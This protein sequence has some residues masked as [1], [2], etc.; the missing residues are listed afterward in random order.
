MF[1]LHVNRP[2]HPMIEHLERAARFQREDRP[3]SSLTSSKLFYGADR[4]GDPGKGGAALIAA[5]LS[6]PT[7][8]RY[9]PLADAR[10][11][12]TENHRHPDRSAA[13]LAR[14]KP[15]LCVFEDLHWADPTT[16]E[17]LDQMIGRIAAER[18]LLLLTFRP[19]FLPPWQGQPHITRFR[20]TAWPAGRARRSS[21]R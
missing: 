12:K 15:V 17:M 1:A 4:Q 9:P 16:L 13:E 19:E 10:S 3:R 18:V 14:G 5:L 21:K 7:N 11:S 2:L 8:G 6:I 20:S